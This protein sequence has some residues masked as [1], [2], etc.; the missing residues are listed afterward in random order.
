LNNFWNFNFLA[1][2]DGH[3]LNKIYSRILKSMHNFSVFWF[4]L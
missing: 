2:D 4:D 1:T 3:L